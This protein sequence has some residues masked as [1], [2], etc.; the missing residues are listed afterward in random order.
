MFLIDKVINHAPRK[1]TVDGIEYKYILRYRIQQE[2]PWTKGEF[3][4]DGVTIYT[5]SKSLKI[6][7]TLKTPS[8]IKTLSDN[9]DPHDLIELGKMEDLNLSDIEQVKDTFTKSGWVDMQ[10]TP[11]IIKILIEN[12]DST[13]QN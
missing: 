11:K 6:S 10:V 13:K 3:F 12:H 1:I 8:I 2:D 9:M 5:E 4:L 7:W